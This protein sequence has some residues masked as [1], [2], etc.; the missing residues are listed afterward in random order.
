MHK[1]FITHEREDFREATELLQRINNHIYYIDELSRPSFVKLFEY[2][3]SERKPFVTSYRVNIQAITRYWNNSVSQLERN[4]GNI[5]QS[6][7][8]S[9][10]DK[11]FT[12]WSQKDNYK[13]R[14]VAVE[15]YLKPLANLCQAYGHDQTALSI[16]HCC[17]DCLIVHEDI[18]SIKLFVVNK[19]EERGVRLKKAKKDIQDFLNRHNHPVV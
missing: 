9:K 1:A 15:E 16:L 10:F 6:A 4:D 14:Y 7:F 3:D 19:I 5:R 18:K 2:F 17:D 13:E 12:N 8:L 11:L